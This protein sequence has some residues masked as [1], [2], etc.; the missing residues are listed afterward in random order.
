[1]EKE[2]KSRTGRTEGVGAGRSARSTIQ[3]IRLSFTGMS[4][5]LNLAG[6]KGR[7][8]PQPLEKSGGTELYYTEFNLK[9][10][11]EGRCKAAD[12]YG[13]ENPD[14][15]SG[16]RGRK[17]KGKDSK[18]TSPVRK[19]EEK[20]RENTLR[21]SQKLQNRGDKGM[22]QRCERWKN[23]YLMGE[24][25][26]QGVEQGREFRAR[27]AGKEALGKREVCCSPTKGRSRGGNLKRCG[28]ASLCVFKGRKTGRRG[29]RCLW[30]HQGS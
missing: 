9:C 30:L 4:Q 25:I 27:G 1:V 3:R 6:Q 29:L 5:N 15:P 19:R 23:Y 24:K 20:K 11:L 17:E 16:G 8:P 13:K 2:Q 14:G 22:K 7:M 21:R 10:E 28:E 18:S 12:T 26:I